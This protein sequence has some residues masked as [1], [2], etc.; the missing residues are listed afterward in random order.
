MPPDLAVGG[1]DLGNLETGVAETVPEGYSGL[2]GTVDIVTLPVGAATRHLVAVVDGYL[3]DGSGMR[4]RQLAA[5]IE[6]A[7]ESR[8]RSRRRLPDLGATPRPPPRSSRAPRHLPSDVRPRAPGPPVFPVATTARIRSSWTPGRSSEERSLPSPLV[9][10]SVRPAL[11]P[12]TRMATS[13]AEA[14][15]T[16]SSNP[17]RESAWTSQPGAYLTLSPQAIADQHRALSESPARGR[18]GRRRPG[19]G[20]E[21]TFSR[22]RISERDS[23]CAG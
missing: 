17:S 1:C 6:F 18:R 14:R 16:A 3:S 11:S 12:I 20:I 9:Q 15:A 5:G 7:T 21:N 19:S 2:D 4:H 13:D 22:L 8:R 10:S 23:M